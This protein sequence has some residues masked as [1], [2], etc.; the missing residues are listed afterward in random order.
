MSPQEKKSSQSGA[1]KAAGDQL[2]LI[3]PDSKKILY[4]NKNPGRDFCTMKKNTQQ[5]FVILKGPRVSKS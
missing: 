3:Y 4:G 1:E 2:T 5:V